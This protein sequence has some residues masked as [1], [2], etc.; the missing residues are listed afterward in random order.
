MLIPV[1]LIYSA[2][3]LWLSLI[4]ELEN[5]NLT[6]VWRTASHQMSDDDEIIDVAVN[7]TYNSSCNSLVYVATERS[8]YKVVDTYNH[9][10]N[11]IVIA[12]IEEIIGKGNS[13]LIV[14]VKIFNHFYTKVFR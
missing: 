3:I 10:Q 2:E 7:N 1:S 11:G 14:H 5:V 4:I 6:R 9:V 12:V 13:T 8:I